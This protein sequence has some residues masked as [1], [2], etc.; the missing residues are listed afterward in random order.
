MSKKFI[1]YCTGKQPDVPQPDET[2]WDKTK[3]IFVDEY[4]MCRDAYTIPMY[5][6]NL[7]LS[8]C[9]DKPDN[10]DYATLHAICQEK[11]IPNTSIKHS[12]WGKTKLKIKKQYLNQPGV[13]T[14]EDYLTG[15]TYTDGNEIEGVCI[16]YIHEKLM[17]IGPYYLGEYIDQLLT[18]PEILNAYKVSTSEVMQ[19]NMVHYGKQWIGM[20]TKNSSIDTKGSFIIGKDATTAEVATFN[21]IQQI[22]EQNSRYYWLHST[23]QTSIPFENRTGNIKATTLIGYN[24]GSYTLDYLQNI[25]K[26]PVWAFPQAV[27]LGSYNGI[28][29]YAGCL[30]LALPKGATITNIDILGG[31]T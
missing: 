6:A 3:R 2:G 17:P 19:Q 9:E 30:I 14:N 21:N 16:Y 31:A 20:N 11:T 23:M 27:R 26:F 8:Y 5:V 22:Y 24:T 10:L 13:T 4:T 15:T 28:T 18:D 12:N 25:C 7:F 1:M 29:F